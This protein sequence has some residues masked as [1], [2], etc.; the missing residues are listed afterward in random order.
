MRT[1]DILGWLVVISW[2]LWW[3]AFPTSVIRFYT[4]FHRGKVKLPKPSGVRMA[5]MLWIVLMGIVMWV[6]S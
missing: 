5:G 4:W 1:D 3:V 2:G 6:S